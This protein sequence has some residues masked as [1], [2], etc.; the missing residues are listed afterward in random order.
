MSNVDHV[1]NAFKALSLLKKKLEALCL[2]AEQNIRLFRL[3]LQTEIF[4]AF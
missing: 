4:I 2:F 1:K 3:Y